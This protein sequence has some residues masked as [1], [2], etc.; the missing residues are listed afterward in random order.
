M[1]SERAGVCLLSGTQHMSITVELTA[2]MKDGMH[3]IFPGEKKKKAWAEESERLEPLIQLHSEPY[4]S[5]I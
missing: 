4:F 3:L 1:S 5:N 2:R